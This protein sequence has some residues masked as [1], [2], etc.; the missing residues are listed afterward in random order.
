M[1]S[2]FG[3]LDDSFSAEM[4]EYPDVGNSTGDF[5]PTRSNPPLMARI[6]RFLYFRVPIGVVSAKELT[7]RIVL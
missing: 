2:E 5:R 6:L 4:P 1:R 7:C 3:R